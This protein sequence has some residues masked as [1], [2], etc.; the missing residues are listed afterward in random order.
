[1]RLQ[2]EVQLKISDLLLPK[3]ENL[4]RFIGRL[5]AGS[6]TFV[7]CETKLLFSKEEPN[8]YSVSTV[9]SPVGLKL[10]TTNPHYAAYQLFEYLLRMGLI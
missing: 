8:L 2:T 3:L 9:A 4:E 10:N 7:F 6:G 5:D 1:M